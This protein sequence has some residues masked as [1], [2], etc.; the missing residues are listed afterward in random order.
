MNAGVGE[1]VGTDGIVRSCSHSAVLSRSRGTARSAARGFAF[2]CAT[3]RP[4]TVRDRFRE[5]CSSSALVRTS[6]V[7]GADEWEGDEAGGNQVGDQL[8]PWVFSAP[9]GLT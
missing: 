1:E 8:R 2:S 9:D 4:S 3:A 5:G 7:L 6:G